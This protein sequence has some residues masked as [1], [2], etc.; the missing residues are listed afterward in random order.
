MPPP[1]RGHSRNGTNQAEPGSPASSR[2]SA[3]TLGAEILVPLAGLIALAGGLSVLPGAYAQIGVWLVVAF[4]VP[5][6]LYPTSRARAR[7]IRTRMMSLVPS[8]IAIRGA[9]RYR[10]STSNSV[11]YP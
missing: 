7:A 6:T 11:E 4:L 9:S 3:P 5:V 2:G 1:G 8:P 10:R